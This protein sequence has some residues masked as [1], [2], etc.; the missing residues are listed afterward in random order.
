MEAPV[1]E[2]KP[3]IKKAFISDI[4]V[5]VLVAGSII[6]A[7]IY[8]NSIVGLGMFI[9]TL[10]ELGIR[11]SGAAL[12]GGSIFLLFFITAIIL[13]MD[14]VALGKSGY[15][16]Y[17]DKLL[18]TKNIFIIQLK[19]ESIPYANIAKI[20]F[21]KKSFLNTFDIILELTGLK[22][23]QV[24]IGYIDD[25]QEVAAKLQQLIMEYKSRYYAE[26]TQ[27]YRLKN[28]MRGI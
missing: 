12:I 6:F 3:D 16:L 10:K 11:I 27:N 8:L 14:Y 23:D 1:A 9:D 20:S 19:E 15:I 22:K 7:L 24:K 17:P 13:I 18:Y 25:A 28:I 5:I 2:I 26:Y 4:S 21:K